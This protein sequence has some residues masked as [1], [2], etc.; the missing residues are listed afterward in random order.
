MLD[1]EVDGNKIMIEFSDNENFWII[2][3]EIV[4]FELVVSG[5]ILFKFDK[6]YDVMLFLKMYDFK[7]WSLNYCGYIYILIFCKICDLFLVMCDRVGFI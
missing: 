2:F 7:M 4:D 5:V 3:L 1:N 6:D